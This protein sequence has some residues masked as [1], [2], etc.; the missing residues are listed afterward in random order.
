MHP[1]PSNLPPSQIFHSSCGFLKSWLGHFLFFTISDDTPAYLS[2][3]SFEEELFNDGAW[4]FVVLRE[5]SMKC[6]CRGGIKLSITDAVCE[7]V[8]DP[9]MIYKVVLSALLLSRSL[10]LQQSCCFFKVN[11]HPSVSYYCDGIGCNSVP[12]LVFIHMRALI[13]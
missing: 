8:K 3:C 13:I 1:P 5:N 4:D 2:Y 12:I 11:Y 6:S 9:I 10:Y 7:C